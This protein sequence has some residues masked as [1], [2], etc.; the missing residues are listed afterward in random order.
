MYQK[1]V[2]IYQYPIQLTEKV[3][4]S[5]RPLHRLT[6]LSRSGAQMP[7]G[8]SGVHAARGLSAE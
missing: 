8:L 6:R 5:P 2:Y 3:T 7:P 1:R 4:R